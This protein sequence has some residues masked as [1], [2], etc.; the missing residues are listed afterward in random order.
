MARYHLYFLKD[1]MVVGSDDIDAENNV[2]ALRIARARAD[3]HSVEVWNAHSLIRT[4]RPLPRVEAG[5][6]G[7]GELLA[8]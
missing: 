5:E 6:A 3:G 8:G 4:I 2:E 7:G 1:R